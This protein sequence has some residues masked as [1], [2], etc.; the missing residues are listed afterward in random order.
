[1]KPKILSRK[2]WIQNIQKNKTKHIKQV[3]VGSKKQENI[4]KKSI[5]LFR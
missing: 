1:M 5:R 2:S 4:I 3:P